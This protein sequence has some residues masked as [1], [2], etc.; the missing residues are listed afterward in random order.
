MTLQLWSRHLRNYTKH[1]YTRKINL[2]LGLYAWMPRPNRT[3][4]RINPTTPAKVLTVQE[5]PILLHIHISHPSPL[6]QAIFNSY[7]QRAHWI[8]FLFLIIF[9]FWLWPW[10]STINVLIPPTPLVKF[11]WPWFLIRKATRT[12]N[13]SKILTTPRWR[14]LGWRD[15]G[16]SRLCIQRIRMA[17]LLPTYAL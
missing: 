7:H 16:L 12:C 2:V 3:M 4:G 14:L 8:A 13:I 9:R 17:T 15:R 1:V 10:S 11:D 6:Y 5:Y